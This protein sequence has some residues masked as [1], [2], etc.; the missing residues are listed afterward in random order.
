VVKSFAPALVAGV[1]SALLYIVVFTFGLG[2]LFLFLPTLPL[3]WLGLGKNSRESLHA[4]LIA[5][6][7][8]VLF[9]NPLNAIFLYLLCLGLPAWYIAHEAL[10]RGR[11]GDKV[12]WF[13]M[14][15]IFARLTM[16]FS[17]FLLGVTLYYHNVEGGLPGMIAPRISTAFSLLSSEVDKQTQ[18]TLEAAAP[19]LAFLVFAVSAWMWCACLYLHAWATNRELIRQKRNIRPSMAIKSFPPPNWMISLLL[20]S[21]CASLIGSPSLAFWGKAS[22]IILLFPYFL[23]GTSLLNER[24]K[25]TEYRYFILFFSYFLM[26]MLLWPVF[27]LSGYGFIYHLILINKYLSAGG[28]TRS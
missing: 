4:M 23:L 27:I 15:A 18:Q 25:K 8:L 12:V 22:L 13:P 17:F 5:T 24:T 19:G 14:T 10:K 9:T 7:V 1:V 16:V 3:F 28:T 2:F 6:V 26:A 20:I 21:A 11:R